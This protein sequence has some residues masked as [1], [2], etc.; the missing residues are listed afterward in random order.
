MSS[1]QNPQ[2]FYF[3]THPVSLSGEEILTLD[4]YIWNKNNDAWTDILLKQFVS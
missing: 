3:Q 4:Q 2:R 1:R